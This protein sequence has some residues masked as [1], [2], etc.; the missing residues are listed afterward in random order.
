MP[1]SGMDFR[2]HSE[3]S[4]DTS[5]PGGQIGLERMGGQALGTASAD[6]VVQAA[7][8]NGEGYRVKEGFDLKAGQAQH[9]NKSQRREREEPSWA[10]L[11][12]NA[13]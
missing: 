3:G 8:L 11:G 6:L 12:A 10:R 1:V 2:I 13:E 7:P 5:N 4:R 9:V